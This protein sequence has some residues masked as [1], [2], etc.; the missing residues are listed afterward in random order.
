MVNRVKI[1]GGP[2]NRKIVDIQNSR[3]AKAPPGLPS[4]PGTDKHYVNGLIL[5]KD[6][7]TAMLLT[8]RK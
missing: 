3:G 7:S 5:N 2:H 1:L 8:I 6:K 4:Y